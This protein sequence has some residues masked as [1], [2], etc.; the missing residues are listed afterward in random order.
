MESQEKLKSTRLEVSKHNSQLM[1]TNI[2]EL[3][4][5]EGRDSD[6]QTKV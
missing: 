6:V 4:R 1:H 5:A 3:G 2:D